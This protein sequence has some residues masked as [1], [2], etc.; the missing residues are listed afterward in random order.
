MVRGSRAGSQAART[1]ESWTV[2]S[3][4][5]RRRRKA[6]RTLGKLVLTI[7]VFAL[8]ILF[9]LPFVWMLSTS[10]KTDPQ[11]YRVP[12]VWIPNPIRWPNYPEALQYV[13]FGH[14]FIN[15][16]KYGLGSTLGAVLS[17]TL[18]AYG[19]S[20]VQWK[21]RNVLFYV[22][23]GTMMLPF[24]VRMIPM[25][26]IF[27]RLGWLNTYLPLVVPSFTGSAYF[28]FLLRQFFMSIPLELSDAAR[29]D[30]ASELGILVR[31]IMPLSVP[32]LAVICLFQFMDSWND[33]MGPL[34]YLRDSA[35][36]PIAMGLEQMRTHSMSV[37]RPL[38]WPYLMAASTV[39]TTPMVLL[40]F[41]TQRTF[42][43][44]ITL[45]G[46]KG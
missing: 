16:L 38:V 43:E 3:Q 22:I 9:F 28:I 45:T 8:S 42:V 18:V 35:Q 46:V 11:V 32:A 36:Y 12:P 5:A 40:Y 25:Y 10:L 13:P 31:I 39:I 19:L 37:N 30:G 44:G 7:L 29:I 14:Y 20:R 6:T 23:L 33:Y 1:G 34:I 2:V 15:T 24:Q 27:H 21:G 41:F 4:A 17:S 26:L